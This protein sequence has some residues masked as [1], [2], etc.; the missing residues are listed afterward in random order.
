MSCNYQILQ[1]G[2][3]KDINKNW[4]NYEPG[5]KKFFFYNYHNIVS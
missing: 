2:D 3:S 1:A 4:E 5:K